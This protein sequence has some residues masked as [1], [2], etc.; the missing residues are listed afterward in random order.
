MCECKKCTECGASLSGFT[1][2]IGRIVGLK[3][4]KKYKGICTKCEDNFAKKKKPT[5]K[6][7]KA[8]KK[9]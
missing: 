9:K 2:M 5:K 3:E 4:S 8:K 7:A 1:G 6:A